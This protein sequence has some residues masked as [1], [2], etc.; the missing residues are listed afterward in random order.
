MPTPVQST[1]S[2]RMAPVGPGTITSSDYDTVTGLCE[3]A[4]PGIGFG[5]AVSQGTLSDK[6]MVLGGS[7]AGFRGP[8]VRD[9]T[10]GAEQDKYLP[11]NNVSAARRGQVM[12]EPGTAVL[13]NDP[14]W[15]D[16]VTGIF[17]KA[18]GTNRVGPVKGAHWVTSCGAGGRAEAY[19]S[20]QT[21][22]D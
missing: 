11:P 17:Y 14:V 20:G 9:I 15:F 21:H 7:L 16:T 22:N 2:E 1:Y 8:S 5:L 12:L 18:T 13:A 6:G 4:A 3:T 19:F 10:L